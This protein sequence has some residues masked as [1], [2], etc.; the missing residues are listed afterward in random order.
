MSCN[1]LAR[2]ELPNCHSCEEQESTAC[3]PPHNHFRRNL[4]F[5]KVVVQ[6]GDFFLD[7]LPLSDAEDDHI[8]LRVR[9]HGIVVENVP[10]IEY[11]LR[12]G[13]TTSLRSEFSRETCKIPTWSKPRNNYSNQSRIWGKAI[14]NGLKFWKTNYLLHC[15]LIIFGPILAVSQITV[16]RFWCHR[17]HRALIRWIIFFIEQFLRKLKKSKNGCFL[18][19]LD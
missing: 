19:I 6:F 11:A 12:E 10:V 17:T 4:Q 2:A 13:L 14:G 5:V 16:I 9:F 7:S 18:V 15:H 8:R 1:L 3:V